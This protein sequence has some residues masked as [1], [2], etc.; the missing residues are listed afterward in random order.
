MANL[1]GP[2]TRGTE[3]SVSDKKRYHGPEDLITRLDKNTLINEG[4]P[5]MIQ[6]NAHR[7]DVVIRLTR[8]KEN[9]DMV[10]YLVTLN[11]QD[12]L[13]GNLYVSDL[14]I[15]RYYE[16]VRVAD[17]G[18]IEGIIQ[19]GSYIHLMVIISLALQM[20]EEGK[21]NERVAIMLTKGVNL[22][23]EAMVSN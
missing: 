6:F 3:T 18:S 19:R 13:G 2:D 20:L 9:D 22:L 17:M 11:G 12:E 15:K 14:D 10:L 23:N 5:I 1:T 4:K 8:F 21:S 7:G 16:R